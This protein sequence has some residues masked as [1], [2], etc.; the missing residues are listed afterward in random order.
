MT[1]MYLFCGPSE[2]GG[3]EVSA[4]EQA[5]R[6]LSRGCAVMVL[7]A[8]ADPCTIAWPAVPLVAVFAHAGLSDEE[9]HDLVD[10]LIQC[11]VDRVFVAGCGVSR[12]GPTTY[13][14]AT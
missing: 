6:A 12:R 4:G 14:A 1:D 5:M 10:A 2:I 13:G 3:R 9:L 7:P 11:G 8:R